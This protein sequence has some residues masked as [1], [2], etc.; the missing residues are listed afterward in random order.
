[1]DCELNDW[2]KEILTEQ[3]LEFENESK[4][5]YQTLE[6]LENI[7]LCFLDMGLSKEHELVQE[8]IAEIGQRT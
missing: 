2:W 6:E 4:Y 1:M 3:G 7:K 8:V 5:K